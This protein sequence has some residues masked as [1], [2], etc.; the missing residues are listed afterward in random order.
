MGLFLDTVP[1]RLD[2][3]GDPDFPALL[4]RVRESSTS[5]YEHRGVPF[6]EL[7]GALNPRRDPGR[8]PLFQV[9]VEYENEGEVPFDP[10]SLTA[11][12]L[13]VPSAR[14]P[15]DLS[16]YLTHHAGGLRFMVEYDTA[17][18]DETTVRRFVD[19][20]EQV[21]RR[22]LAAPDAPL[23]ELT[24]LTAADRETLARWE[25]PAY[26]EDAAPPGTLHGLFERQ[27]RRTP[28]ATALI[29]GD[30]RRSYAE[31]DA[32][33]DRLAR[34][35]RTRGAA[36]GERVAVLLPR[37]PHLI[38]ALLAVLKSGAA[39]LPLD[40]SLP[41]PRLSLLLAD[42]TP[43]L[44]L[45]SDAA[46]TA[47]PELAT[48]LPVQRVEQVDDTLPTGPVPEGARP[49]DPAY[50]IH[51]SGSTGRPKGVVVP[52][53]GPANLVRGHLSRHPALRT[54]QWT[55]PA[56]DVSV[57]EIFTTLA[58]GAELVL[59]DDA[60]RHDPAAVAEAVRRHEVR[61]MFMPCTPLKYLMETAPE[62]PSLR[63]L[64]S[65]A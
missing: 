47:H 27:A 65:A 45:T 7:V 48:G 1:L 18:F 11:T 17:L 10:P 15:F 60:V 12:L 19:Y 4:H 24:A 55:S 39:Y 26:T 40:P 53:R 23:P 44:L 46:L 37:G 21:L 8:N 54:L 20:V 25:H 62:L 33:A 51:T 42:G 43:V 36:R 6:D 34:Q 32:A 50:C 38:T 56:F 2:L 49:E 16:V 52:H 58:S 14:A 59:V 63:E 35:L 9:M 29:S 41:T 61:R 13:D 22:A 5:A 57:Q 30:Q 64:F 28:D 3:T 31:L